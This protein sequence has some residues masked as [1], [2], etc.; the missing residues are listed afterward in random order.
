MTKNMKRPTA[1]ASD[2]SAFSMWFS[3]ITCDDPEWLV[4]ARSKPLC[5]DSDQLVSLWQSWPGHS[6]HVV[7][8]VS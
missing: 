3:A 8:T 5:M 1:V 7:R 6:K 4:L 2:T